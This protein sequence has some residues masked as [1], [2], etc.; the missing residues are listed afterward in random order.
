[1]GGGAAGGA[2]A[3]M[4][5][6]AAL[7]LAA[8]TA[9]ALALVLTLHAWMAA[10]IRANQLAHETRQL[11]ALMQRAAPD[12]DVGLPPPH[13]LTQTL[14]HSR[15]HAV[16]PVAK[17]GG[18]EGGEGGGEG[19]AL[20]A[21]LVRADVPDGY[22]GTIALL[23]AVRRDDKAGAPLLGIVRHRETAGIADFRKLLDY[24]EETAPLR[25][26][27]TIDQ[28]GDTAAFLGSDLAAGITGQVIYVD[29]GFNIVGMPN[30]K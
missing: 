7:A 2:A 9:A 8:I 24:V 26:N 14:S 20:T 28:V 11:R 15:L 17:G 3:K 18:G 23:L 12:V 25:R 4:I 1:M 19:G 29:S 22:N 6:R 16:Y 30:P 5:A 27:V 13:A 21:V 10:D